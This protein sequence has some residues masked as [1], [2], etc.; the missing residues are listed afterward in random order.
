MSEI[1]PAAA[2]FEYKGP[3]EDDQVDD[4]DDEEPEPIRDSRHDSTI[5]ERQQSDYMKNDILRYLE[6]KDN[7][8]SLPIATK[9]EITRMLMERIHQLN[10]GAHPLINWTG[11]KTGLNVTELIAREELRQRRIPFIVRR[12]FPNGK[13]EDWKLEDFIRLDC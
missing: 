6:Q 13:Y 9:Y 7:R 2:E 11:Q 5:L 1:T 4:I 8:K 12:T 10:M 3:D